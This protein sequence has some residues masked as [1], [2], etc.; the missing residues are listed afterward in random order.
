M[1]LNKAKLI[2]DQEL[3][4]MRQ[5]DGHDY[6][7]IQQAIRQAK[8]DLAFKHAKEIVEYAVF[9]LDGGVETYRL[10]IGIPDA[11]G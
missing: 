6:D 1:D 7:L 9:L 10:D 8:R 11:P 5:M 4:L 2:M 3:G